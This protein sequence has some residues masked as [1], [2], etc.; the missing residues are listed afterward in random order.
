MSDIQD[1]KYSD[2]MNDRDKWQ[3]LAV[4]AIS[5]V[6]SCDEKIKGM[7]EQCCKTCRSDVAAS[8]TCGML[9]RRPDN[10]PGGLEEARDMFFCSEWEAKDE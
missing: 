5:V 1:V 8:W 3:A 2:L 10:R 9:V 4:D 6:G 7:K